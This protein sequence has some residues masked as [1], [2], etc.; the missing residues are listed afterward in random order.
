MERPDYLTNFEWYYFCNHKHFVDERFIE[1][2]L[3]ACE[4]CGYLSSYTNVGWANRG[5]EKCNSPLN[6]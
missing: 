6:W 1:E 2:K 4:V 3:A 5:C